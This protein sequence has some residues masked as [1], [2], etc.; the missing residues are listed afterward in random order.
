VTDE[1]KNFALEFAKTFSVKKSAEVLRKKMSIAKASEILERE[2]IKNLVISELIGDTVSPT[3]ERIL[4]EYEKIAFADS[5]NNDVKVAD[6]LRALDSY[7]SITEKRA[8]KDSDGV[9]VNVNY[10]YGEN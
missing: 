7:R 4:L 2:E 1:E 9:T 8:A 3:E 6:K 5:S 10:D